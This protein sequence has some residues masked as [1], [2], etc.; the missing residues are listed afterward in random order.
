MWQSNIERVLLS[1]RGGGW[2]LEHVET[3][4]YTCAIAKSLA[5]HV[6]EDCTHSAHKAFRLRRNWAPKKL[7][8]KCCVYCSDG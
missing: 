7:F 4:W 1:V 5:C 3:A 8:A 2:I 6:S